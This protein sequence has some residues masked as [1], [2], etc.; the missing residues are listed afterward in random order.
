MTA[1]P[2]RDEIRASFEELRD[3]VRQLVEIDPERALLYLRS[4]TCSVEGW[5]RSLSDPC[6][7]PPN[8]DPEPGR[9]Q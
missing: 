1:P 4:A 6:T 7:A 3:A 9:R 5:T 8:R 2:T